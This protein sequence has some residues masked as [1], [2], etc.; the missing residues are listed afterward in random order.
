MSIEFKLSAR[1]KR[2]PEKV[3]AVATDLPQMGKWAGKDIHNISPGPVGVGSTFQLVNEFMGADQKTNYR[4]T[5]YEPGRRFAYQGSGLGSNLVD[6][7]FSADP[8][9]TQVATTI[10][11][12][13]KG[14]VASL[15]KNTVRDMAHNSLVRFVKFCETT[16]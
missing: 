11:V 9:G 6:M 2:P 13:L 12:Q 10:S 7:A 15:A 4:V 5:I 16:E 8:L 1:I 3:F 14:V